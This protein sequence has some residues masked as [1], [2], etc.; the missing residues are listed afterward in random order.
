MVKE[1]QRGFPHFDFFVDTVPHHNSFH[2]STTSIKI[3]QLIESVNDTDE[4][5]DEFHATMGMKEKATNK[6]S[7]SMH[8]FD[9]L[10]RRQFSHQ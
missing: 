9:V 6:Y 3:P 4:N 8:V 1:N 10:L 5:L 2:P 7:R